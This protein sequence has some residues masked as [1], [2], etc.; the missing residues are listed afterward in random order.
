[1]TNDWVE[2]IFWVVVIGVVWFRDEVGEIL[3]ALADRIRK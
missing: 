3:S 1:M 2:L